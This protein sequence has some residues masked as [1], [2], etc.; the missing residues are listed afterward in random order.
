LPLT[1]LLRAVTVSHP[2]NILTHLLP[3]RRQIIQITKI[4]RLNEYLDTRWAAWP[5]LTRF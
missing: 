3:I 1:L 2:I 5:V 4:A